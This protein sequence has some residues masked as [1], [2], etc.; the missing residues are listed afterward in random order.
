MKDDTLYGIIEIPQGSIVKYEHDKLHE[1]LFADRVLNQPIPYNYG[2]IENTLAPDG[3]PLDVFVLGDIPLYPLS[4]VRLEIIGVLKC[5]DNGDQDD[6]I[7]AHMG[8]PMNNWYAGMGVDHIRT[9]L[10]TYKDGFVV[11]GYEPIE[12]AFAVIEQCKD[13]YVAKTHYRD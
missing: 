1:V 8:V 10:M 4:R 5:V 13:S 7:I 6:K 3:D 12:T 9:Y 11:Q 2:Y